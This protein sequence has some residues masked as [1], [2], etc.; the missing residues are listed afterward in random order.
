M[1]VILFATSFNAWYTRAKFALVETWTQPPA[2]PVEVHPLPAL[3]REAELETIPLAAA[4]ACAGLL[5]REL[6][7]RSETGASIVAIERAGQTLVNPGPDEELRADDKLLLL[8]SREQL[9][10]ARQHLARARVD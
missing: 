5:I 6:Q 8:G 10:R 9:A 4:S 2:E 7:L 1:L 3:L